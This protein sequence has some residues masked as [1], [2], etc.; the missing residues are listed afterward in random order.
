MKKIITSF[1]LLLTL[2][3]LTALSDTNKELAVGWELWYPY[4]YRNEQQK[5]VGLDLDIFNAIVEKLN[6]SVN[7]TELPWKR[8]L[9]Y[10]KTGEMD[11]AMGASYTKERRDYA[12]YSIP[13]RLETVK[14]FVKKNNNT[15]KKIELNHLKD[16]AESDYMIGVEGGYYYGEEYQQLIKTTEFRAHITEVIDLEQNIE[17]LMKGHIDGVLVDPFTMQAFIK[18]YKMYN[19]FE[20]HSLNIYADNIHIMVSK[21]SQHRNL[22]PQIN[23]AI[24]SL[25]ADGTLDKILTEW[26]NIVKSNNTGLAQN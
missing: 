15:N 1:C 12:L 14:L 22:I 16:L 4:Q 11:I 24:R 9:N 21:K 6:L 23:K 5:L 2:H 26:N 3:P 13:Y 10:I 17:L 19:E 20:Q 7:Y 25:K 18:K 8:H